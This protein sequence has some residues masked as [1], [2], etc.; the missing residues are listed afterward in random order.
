M[1]ITLYTTHCP[2]CSV[3][4]KKLAL[5]HIEYE[6]I[7]DTQVMLDKGFVNVPILDVDGI[8]MDFSKA[9]AWI[10]EH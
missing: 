2:K 7:T 10:N 6:E 3:L 5:K 4:E 8:I 9:N 1:S